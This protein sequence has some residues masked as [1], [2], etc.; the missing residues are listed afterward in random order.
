MKPSAA[1]AQERFNFRARNELRKRAAWLV[2][3]IPSLCFCRARPFIAQTAPS[4]SCCST[5]PNSATPKNAPLQDHLQWLCCKVQSLCRGAVSSSYSTEL[6]H[7]RQWAPAH[8]R[9]GPALLLCVS[10]AQG[11][12]AALAVSVAHI[13]EHDWLACYSSGSTPLCCTRAQPALPPLL[14][15]PALCLSPRLHLLWYFLAQL[16][17]AGLVETAVFDTQDGLYD[18]AWSEE[19]ENVVLAASGDGSVKVYDLAA[20]PMA[21][22]LRVFREHKHEVR[23]ILLVGSGWLDQAPAG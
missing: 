5:S 8:S 23:V 16:T 22:P 20:P 6:W 21:N 9:G 7:H 17:P 13:I 12:A 14:A 11:P 2:I 15:Q 1:A 19:N 3:R 18:C 10:L 4:T